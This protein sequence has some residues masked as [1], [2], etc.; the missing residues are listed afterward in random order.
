MTRHVLPWVRVL[1]L[2]L[3]AIAL[4]LISFLTTGSVI[5][6]DPNLALLFQSS[7]LLVVLGSLVLE[8]YF[9]APGDAL[10]NGVTALITVL[11]F[12]TSKHFAVWLFL[13]I[14]LGLVILASAVSVGLQNQL[15][16]TGLGAKIQSALYVISS[17]I[18]QA[19]VVFSVVFLVAITFFVQVSTTQTFALLAFWGIYV[20]MWPLGIPQLLS[21]LRA[22]QKSQRQLIGKLDRVDSPNIARVALDDA[23][24]WELDTDIP[25]LVQIHDKTARWAIRLVSEVTADGRWATLLL[26][27]LA[28]GFES[29]PGRV[30]L[31]AEGD[32]TPSVADLVKSMIGSADA[33]IV[34][35]L[36]DGSSSMRLRIEVLPT[37]QLHLGQLLAVPTD[38][39]PVL[40]QIVE[41]ETTEEPFGS[42]RYGS[43]VA[44]AVQVGRL[45][46]DGRFARFDWL[47]AVNAPAF[48]I[49]TETV[50]APAGDFVLGKIPG[51]SITLS[52]D[53]VEALETHTAILGVT[54]SGK[55]EL[56]FDLIRHTLKAGVK[57]VCIDLTSQYAP[58]L[59]DLGPTELSI[60]EKQANDLSD[61]L[62]DVETGAYGA[63]NE[64][65]VLATFAKG[66]RDD[67]ETRLTAFLKLAGGQLGLIELKEISNT[68]ATLW[69][70]EMYLSTLLRLARE[71][72]TDGKILVVVEEAHT[73][74]PEASFTGLGDYDSKGTVAKITQLALQ[75]R[76]Y[77]V[78]LLVLAQRTAT[79]S[80]SVLTQCNTVISFSCIDDTSV[81][82]LRNVYGSAIAEGVPELPR[83]RAIAHGA[84]IRSDVPLAFDVPFESGKGARKSWK[85]QTTS[86]SG[87]T[88]PTSLEP[89]SDTSAAPDDSVPF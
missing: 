86:T 83:L 58:R 71:G 46:D 52:G 18:G 41:G 62:F 79:V 60:S 2:G 12:A 40:Y 87:S 21:R 8:R 64:K 80:K 33:R 15:H 72:Q 73:V 68:K 88:P 57:V 78:G 34:G 54:G 84:W 45:E 42:L 17:S 59:A 32:A 49:E 47:P 25:L 19:R 31:P 37:A 61:R 89:D 55:T 70:T 22:R 30:E 77:G 76:K 67:V 26:A 23:F 38:V 44:S 6:Q 13:V 69:I 75:G 11:P 24:D 36:R 20:A 51:T 27:D 82:F 39:G 43:Q 66:V 5:P 74:M 56:A 9:T 10:V 3:A 65:K 1:I 50:A 48:S 14:Y 29:S 85:A 28:S 4:G 81:G 7:L 16:L 63:P 53:F 35:L